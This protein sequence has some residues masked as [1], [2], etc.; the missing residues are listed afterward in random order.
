MA[1]VGFDNRTPFEPEGIIGRVVAD[2]DSDP[3]TIWIGTAT[4]VGRFTAITNAHIVEGWKGTDQTDKSRS[5]PRFQPGY[6][7]GSALDRVSVARWT[8]YNETSGTPWEDDFAII[9][10]KEPI[11]DRFGWYELSTRGSITNDFVESVT[12]KG[13]PDDFNE[14][15]IP[16]VSVGVAFGRVSGNRAW[17]HDLDSFGGAS[18]SA[19]VSNNDGKVLGVHW[20]KFNDGV[21]YNSWT[22]ITEQFFNAVAQKEA[23]A[24]NLYNQRVDKLTGQPRVINQV[25]NAPDLRSQQL[26]TRDRNQRSW[27]DER[28]GT[29]WYVDRFELLDFPGGKSIRVNMNSNDFDTYLIVRDVTANYQDIANNGDL[30]GSNA[31]SITFMAEA[32]HKYEIFATSMTPDALGK[33]NLDVNI[34]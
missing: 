31:S 14:G 15:E 18:G 24:Q 23:E 10:F 4:L 2:D 34:L 30:G 22:P 32:G 19:I 8:W 11:G 21:G 28:Q 1:I 26:D 9:T 20:G 29:A 16:S 27:A 17:R 13:Y 6:A 5:N 7:E 25:G 33:Y 3:G 12:M